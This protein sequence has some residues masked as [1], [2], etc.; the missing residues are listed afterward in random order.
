MDGTK[1][2]GGAPNGE[3]PNAVLFDM[4]GV[5]V[6][7]EDFWVE[8]E[9]ET[10]FPEV[11]EEDVAADE[12]TG[13]NYREIYDYLDS[14]YQT[15]A[16]KEEFIAI[17]DEAAKKLYSEH[18]SLMDGFHDLLA[19]LRNNGTEIALV[20]SSPHHWIEIVLDRFDLE[21]SE[22]VSAEDIDAPGKPEPAIFEHAAGL[23]GAR[24]DECAAVEDS[25]NGVESA[26][27][28]GT[29]CI[30]YPNGAKELDL[31]AADMVVSSPEE[32]REELLN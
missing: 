13:M 28:A 8:L 19:D 26:V 7:S 22:V 16:T 17:Y 32:L 12:I 5:I 9:E 14:E 25:E 29:Y 1:P 3:P 10:I 6:N 2:S 24:A 18:V 31:S 4:D 20:S 23:L 21:F 11:V 15:T 30:G 27:R